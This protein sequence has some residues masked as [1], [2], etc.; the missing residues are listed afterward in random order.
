MTCE[1]IQMKKELLKQTSNR[2]KEIERLLSQN[3][4]ACCSILDKDDVQELEE[5]L[6]N[7]KNNEKQIESELTF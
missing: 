6:E 1:S 4:R 5:E 7:L 3:V 2:I